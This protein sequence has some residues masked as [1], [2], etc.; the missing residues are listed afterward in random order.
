MPDLRLDFSVPV[1]LSDTLPLLPL[2][3]GVL[4][5]GML[6]S[7]GIGRERSRAAVA[8]AMKNDKTIKDIFGK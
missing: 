4:L 1:N 3:R 5:P 7:F 8:A 6:S 2:R